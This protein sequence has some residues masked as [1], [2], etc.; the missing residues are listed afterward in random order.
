M[1]GKDSKRPRRNGRESIHMNKEAVK[2][3]PR[4]EPWT[5]LCV[6]ISAQKFARL[7]YKTWARRPISA[8][9]NVLEQRDRTLLST[10]VRS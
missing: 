7:N 4:F 8:G 10:V 3:A 1:A 6:G 5:D 9:T 2:A